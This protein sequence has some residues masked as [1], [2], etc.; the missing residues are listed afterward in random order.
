MTLKKM[1]FIGLCSES[2]KSHS[3]QLFKVA[4][5][6]LLLCLILLLCYSLLF[7]LLCFLLLFA[8]GKVRWDTHYFVGSYYTTLKK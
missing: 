1:T 3:T 6:K 4:L 7:N 5:F 8:Q 2:T